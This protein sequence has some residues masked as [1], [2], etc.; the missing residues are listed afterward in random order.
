MGKKRRGEE[1]RRG[2]EPLGTSENDQP[3]DRTGGLEDDLT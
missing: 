3:G 2:E 1:D